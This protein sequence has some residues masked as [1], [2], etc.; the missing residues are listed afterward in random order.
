MSSGFQGT[1]PLPKTKNTRDL[2][3]YFWGKAQVHVQ[4]QAQI[5]M[6][7]LDSPKLGGGSPIAPKLWG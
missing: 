4:I 2:V 3:R 1:Y 5:K 7:Y 6:T